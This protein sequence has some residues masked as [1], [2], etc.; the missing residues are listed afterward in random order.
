MDV[1]GSKWVLDRFALIY[2]PFATALYGILRGSDQL[3]DLLPTLCNY[4]STILVCFGSVVGEPTLF[5]FLG[6]PILSSFLIKEWE[7]SSPITLFLIQLKKEKEKVSSKTFF[8][9]FF[10]FWFSS[11]ILLC[12]F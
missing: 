7:G 5:L 11:C 8:P 9:T 6:S 2:A 10:T 4:L 1:D 3:F 12:H